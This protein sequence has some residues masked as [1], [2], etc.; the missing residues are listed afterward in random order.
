MPNYS[1]LETSALLDMLV[2]Y[3]NK[4]SELKSEGIDNGENIAQL[5]QELVEIQ[6]ALAT[7]KSK[8]AD[9]IEDGLMPDNA[10]VV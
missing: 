8:P 3:T 5:E 6:G 2:Q 7:R 1:D 4:Y 9:L 10:P